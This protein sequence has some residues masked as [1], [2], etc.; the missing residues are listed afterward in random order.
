MF[1]LKVL[2]L[3]IIN[4]LNTNSEKNA[5]IM[6]FEHFHILILNTIRNLNT[7]FNN[8]NTL[9]LF[10]TNNYMLCRALVYEDNMS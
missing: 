6:Y 3:K 1:I 8:L 5:N 9:K 2:R 4:I 10:K 7:K